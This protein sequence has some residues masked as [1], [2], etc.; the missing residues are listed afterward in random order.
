VKEIGIQTQKIQIDIL[1]ANA[2][3]RPNH[4]DTCRTAMT[5]PAT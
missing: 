1:L 4:W 5:V 2:N 3:R